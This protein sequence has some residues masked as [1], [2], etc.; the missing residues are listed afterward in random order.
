[1]KRA[2]LSGIFHRRI[3][4]KT[5][6]SSTDLHTHRALSL[7]PGRFSLYINFLLGEAWFFDVMSVWTCVRT[8]SL[9]DATLVVGWSLAEMSFIWCSFCLQHFLIKG[10]QEM[11]ILYTC[12]AP[13]RR[14]T[15]NYHIAA[16]HK[17][18]I[19]TKTES[20]GVRGPPRF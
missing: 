3:P 19:C 16:S 4:Q 10:P 5:Q 14:P 11:Y 2:L 17:L 12:P 18:R 6:S 20:S 15:W 9:V 7:K 13:N 1:M 8:S